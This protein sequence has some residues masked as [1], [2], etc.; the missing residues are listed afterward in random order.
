MFL[1]VGGGGNAYSVVL[2]KHDASEKSSL[3]INY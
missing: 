2:K 1:C 3:L